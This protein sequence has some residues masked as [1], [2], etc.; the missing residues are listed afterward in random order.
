MNAG[1]TSTNWPRRGG[2]RSARVR[3]DYDKVLRQRTALLKTAG[4]ARHRGDRS[5]LDTLD[6][7]DGHLAAHGAQLIAARVELVNQLAP[8]VEKAYQLL[9]PSSGPAAIQYRSGVDA[10]ESEA[11][12]GHRTMWS[13]SR[14]RCSTR[15]P[16]G[17]M[18]NSNAASAWWART[19]TTSNCDW[20]IKSAKGF[21]SHGESWS[22]ALA[23][24]LAAYELLRADGG[25]PVL[26]LDDVFAELDNARRQALANVAASRS[27]F[28]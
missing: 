13:C 2:Q 15:S 9:A 18:P 20:A 24:R 27:R 21:A 6:V 28:W 23:L 19:G 12:A 8:E 17:V 25:D 7:W 5:V 11:A 1:A 26:L 16:A 3:A 14:P 4:A 22:M 10:V